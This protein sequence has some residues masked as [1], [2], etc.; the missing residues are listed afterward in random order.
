MRRRSLLASV[1]AGAAGLAGCL[2]G[3]SGSGKTKGT[4]TSTPEPAPATSFTLKSIDAS[5]KIGLGI[6]YDVTLTVE[7]TGEHAG[8]FRAPVQVRKSDGKGF[9]TVTTALIYAEAGE[10]QRATVTLSAFQTISTVDV[11]V[12]NPNNTWSVDVV[13]PHLPLG[14]PFRVDSMR[15]A[16]TDVRLRDVYTYHGATYRPSDGKTLAVATVEL[17]N[18]RGDARWMP[19]VRGFT[20]VADGGRNEALTSVAYDQK[21]LDRGDSFTCTLP[22]EVPTEAEPDALVFRYDGQRQ[23]RYA[24]WSRRF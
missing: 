5:P 4:A 2:G 23:N 7:N 19:N 15:I 12:A 16:Y 18:S 20:V 13:G 24:L 17:A 21:I 10:T 3:N 8:V 1:G 11:R 14:T 22:F 6:P 9:Q